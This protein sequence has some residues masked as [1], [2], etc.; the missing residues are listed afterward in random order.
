MLTYFKHQLR[1]M[2]VCF[3]ID[4]HL[5]CQVCVQQIGFYVACY[6][7]S[8]LIL[9]FLCSHPCPDNWWYTEMLF[10][11][12]D[13][14]PGLVDTSMVYFCLFLLCQK[15]LASSWTTL[16]QIKCHIFHDDIQNTICQSWAW[17]VLVSILVA[18]TGAIHLAMIRYCHSFINVCWSCQFPIAL[19]EILAFLFYLYWN[20]LT[21]S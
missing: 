3:S 1:F 14:L 13:V 5:K 12:Q 7:C 18:N 9:F 4:M 21:D 19:F 20:L 6:S 11:W 8:L 2:W 15:Q 16:S 17:A 10:W